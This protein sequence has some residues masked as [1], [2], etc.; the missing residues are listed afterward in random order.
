MTI[1]RD[2]EQLGMLYDQ[3]AVMNMHLSS[4][5]LFRVPVISEYHGFVHQWLL[6]YR[7]LVTECY[8]LQLL[9]PLH[10]M[11]GS[12]EIQFR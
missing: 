1:R 4:V 5:V 6:L 2:I 12:G 9:I 8:L 11:E 7:E 10:G 3:H